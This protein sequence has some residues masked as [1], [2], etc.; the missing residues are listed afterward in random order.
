MAEVK[1]PE[2]GPDGDRSKRPIHAERKVRIA[3][4]GAGQAGLCFAYKLQ[5]SFHNFELVVYEKNEG[6]GGVWYENKYPG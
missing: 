6:V 2:V 1:P 5:R 4:I 3:C